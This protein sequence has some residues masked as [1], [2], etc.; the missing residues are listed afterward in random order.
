MLVVMRPEAKPQ[1]I[2]HVIEQ[3]EAVGM[4]AHVSA[5]SYRTI[6]GAVGDRAK[7]ADLALEAMP[8]VEHAIPISKSYK[9]VAR[10]FRPEGST[11]KV[12][13]ALVG[14]ERFA[15]IAGPPS[16]EDPDDTVDL[17]RQLAG[18]GT[19]ILRGG[20][21]KLRVP[22]HALE[23]QSG[24][25]LELLQRCREET[26]L[27]VVTEV[28]DARDIDRLSEVADCLQ[29]GADNMQNFI[30]LREVGLQRRPVLL[31]RGMSNTVEELLMSAEYIAKG[32]NQDIILC[33]RGVRTFDHVTR[34]TLDF[35][36][37][38]ALRSLTHL[39][40]ITDPSQASGR[41]DLV[42]PLALASVAA[43]ADGVMI[44]VHQD[45]T[46]ASHNGSQAISIRQLR[47]LVSRLLR[48]RAAMADQ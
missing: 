5:G 6:I 8:G 41:A 42:L 17:V 18:S 21:F 35:A 36:A 15:T 28:Q 47:D 1:E 26:G 19:D 44:D 32:G 43:G 7:L 9:F 11:V 27:P 25:T 13:S 31:K 10:E 45:P 38:A 39:P 29:I 37:V 40:I 4:Q 16:I 30:L 14:G 3:I 23:Q 33:E 24:A 46:S 34:A 22:G 2:E 20:A 12:G 48:V